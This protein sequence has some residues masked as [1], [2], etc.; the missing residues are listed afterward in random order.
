MRSTESYFK[1]SNL[2]WVLI[3]SLVACY[4]L[5]YPVT[6]PDHFKFLVPWLN[7]IMSSDGVAV[8]ATDF[9]NYT[10]GYISFLSLVSLTS[11]VL[12]DLA[13]IKATSVIGSV[14]SAVGVAACLSA[15]G[16][17]NQARLNAAFAYLLLPTV[18]LNGIGWGQAD[19][20]YSAFLLFALAAVLKQRPLTAALMFAVAV[21]FK[22]QA[23]FFAPFLLGYMLRTPAKLALAAALLIP[24][25]LAV[26][27]I[28][29]V[30]GRPLQDVLMIYAGQA[31]TFT[32]LSMNAGNFWLLVDL[33]GDPAFLAKHH[34]ALV[35]VGLVAASLAGL[36]VTWRVYKAPFS[37]I[38][39]LYLA[40]VCALLMPF[41]LPKMHERFFF[42]AESVVFL[43]ALVN[44]RW[45]P[46][47][48][49]VQLSGVAMYS[50][51]HD[52]FG[53]RAL[54]GGPLIAFVGIT[55]MFQCIRLVLKSEHSAPE[56]I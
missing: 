40:C 44:L 12:S 3:A 30:S 6:Q 49:V 17:S 20:F 46:A 23:M 2:T 28:Y 43:L 52:T 25:Y 1:D 11:P 37:R 54:F 47:C 15:F 45:W 24:I 35:L 33:L 51:Y 16:W 19:A 26:N 50:I 9:S 10:G 13:I 8:F 34:R 55:L 14:M 4:A 53:L 41:L 27:S 18:M 22:L 36:W 29:L 32:R 7:A 21:S 5:M 31:Q 56:N 48:V 38:M 42:P 39:M